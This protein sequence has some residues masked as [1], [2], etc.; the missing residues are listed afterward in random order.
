MIANFR[1]FLLKGLEMEHAIKLCWINIRLK[2]LD[3]VRF[4]EGSKC[5][6]IPTN[7]TAVWREVV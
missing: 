1:E 3:L 2:G 5:C 7:S 4:N 6:W